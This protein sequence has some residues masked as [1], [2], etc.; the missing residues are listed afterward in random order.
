MHYQ[1]K[2]KDVILA[3][4]ILHNMIVEDE[5]Y[6]T[7]PNNWDFSEHARARGGRTL[8]THDWSEYLNASQV[9]EDI[10]TQIIQTLRRLCLPWM[11]ETG[12]ENTFRKSA[13]RSDTRT[14]LNCNWLSFS[15]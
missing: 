6:E 11:D 12:E 4:V 15:G 3:C 10:E 1:H 5:R 14:C 9:I 7:L 2:I 8:S 13:L